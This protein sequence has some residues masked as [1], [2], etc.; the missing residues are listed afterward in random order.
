MHARRIAVPHI[1]VQ[2]RDWLT[3][4]DVDELPVDDDGHAGVVLAQ[5][6]PDVPSTQYGPV[7]SSRLRMQV[8]LDEKISHS[9]VLLAVM[10]VQLEWWGLFKATSVP[11]LWSLPG[12]P[13]LRD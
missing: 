8:G 2:V 3:C 4:L 12:A 7:S 6:R 10:P 9:S 5:V 11:R 1:P 13:P